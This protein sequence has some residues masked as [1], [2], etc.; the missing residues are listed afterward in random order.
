MP[1][2]H[3]DVF[4]PNHVR[5]SVPS[6][7][8]RLN[9][10]HHARNAAMNDRYGVIPLTDRIDFGMMEVVEVEHDGRLQKVVLRENGQEKNRVFVVMP[11]PGGWLVKTVWFNLAS[12][13]HRTLRRELYEQR[14]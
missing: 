1:L 7:I 4:L 9:Y 10:S 2:Y 3:K 6:G 11:K 5:E 8:Q 14:R 13:R 12:D